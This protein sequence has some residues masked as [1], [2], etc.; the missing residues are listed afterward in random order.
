LVETR[1][2]FFGAIMTLGHFMNSSSTLP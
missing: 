1:L 2:I